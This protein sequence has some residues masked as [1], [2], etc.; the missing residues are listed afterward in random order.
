MGPRQ[1]VLVTGASGFV[2]RRL[3]RKLCARGY[4]VWGASNHALPSHTATHSC[5]LDITKYAGIRDLLLRIRPDW[6]IH[7]AAKSD[8]R[9]SWDFPE[10]A[11]QINSSGTVH[12]L[13]AIRFASPQSR[14]LFVSSSQVYGAASLESSELDESL[15][16]SPISPYAYSKRLAEM[17]CLQFAGA[18]GMDI[19]I[20]RPF[21]HIGAGQP[22]NYVFPDWCGQVARM[23]HRGS[24]GLLKTGNLALRREFLHVDDVI[25]A[26]E[27]L[28][29]KG[30]RGRIYNIATGRSILLQDAAG[31]LIQKAKVPIRLRSVTS[32]LR[33]D[34]VSV[35]TGSSR[36]I[37]HLGW[38]P[39]RN[40]NDALDEL[41]EE[42][43][44]REYPL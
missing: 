38:A 17:A 36:R 11:V 2:G 19:V 16:P 8:P 9:F 28:L 32:R 43:R 5:R 41:L 22:S 27:I 4:T 13:N 24:R 3:C 15:A 14:L 26:Y 44:G 6:I 21:N 25:D 31:Y 34:D 40:L 33:S 35:I 18:Y 10:K 7:L 42:A 39:Q 23:E 30:E 20:A 12:L 1:N 37:R 29:R